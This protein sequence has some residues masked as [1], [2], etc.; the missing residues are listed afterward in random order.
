MT[1][2]ALAYVRVA[3]RTHTHFNTSTHTRTLAT[4]HT[5]H[6]HTF[7]HA[8]NTCDTKRSSLPCKLSVLSHT[9]CTHSAAEFNSI[10]R[11]VALSLRDSNFGG[12]VPQAWAQ[13]SAQLDSVDFSGN[14][15]FAQPRRHLFIA[16]PISLC[17]YRR[18]GA[19]CLPIR[20]AQRA[21]A[22][23]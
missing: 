23:I 15:V 5:H 21:R 10:S 14:Q 19:I 11:L 1:L 17:P 20:D 16:N 3:S 13:A 9:F 22:S 7:S 18:R 4:P 2:A 8:R 12:A 6:A